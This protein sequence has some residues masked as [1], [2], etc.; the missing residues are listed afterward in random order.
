[1]EE[2]VHQMLREHVN[3]EDSIMKAL[4]EASSF[5]HDIIGEGLLNAGIPGVPSRQDSLP[6]ESWMRDSD[7]LKLYEEPLLKKGEYDEYGITV[8][9][10]VWYL[11]SLKEKEKMSDKGFDEFVKVGDSFWRSGMAIEYGEDDAQP[12]LKDTRNDLGCFAPVSARRNDARSLWEGTSGITGHGMYSNG[13]LEPVSQ[14]WM[15]DEELVYANDERAMLSHEDHLHLVDAVVNGMYTMEDMLSF[16]LYYG[17]IVLGEE[18]LNLNEHLNEAWNL[19]RR[20]CLFYMRGATV[21]TDDAAFS[22]ARTQATSDMWRFACILEKQCPL[23]VLTL[24][25]RLCVVHLPRQELVLGSV[26]A[27]MEFWV[28]RGVQA[29]KGCVQNATNFPDIVMGNRLTMRQSLD[30]YQFSHHDMRQLADLLSI[31][32]GKVIRKRPAGD[33]DIFRD[34][35]V[36]F[37]GAATRSSCTDIQL[38]SDNPALQKMVTDWI[39]ALHGVKHTY[40]TIL[41]FYLV[42]GKE[43]NNVIRRLAKMKMYSTK[44]A[45]NMECVGIDVLDEAESAQELILP[46]SCIQNKVIFHKPEAGGD[47]HAIYLFRGLRHLRSKPT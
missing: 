27:I 22:S 24:N 6:E 28:E 23:N 30:D 13:Y 7:I 20:A 12:F 19:L 8:G 39:F 35:G 37:L 36:Y 15:G 14:T 26:S 46:I 21:Y 17:M 38:V 5:D 34:D 47:I 18:L 41:S 31:V 16:V 42:L 44:S 2:Q 10:V 3:M 45:P 25:L 29:M 1:M 4:Q 32:S 11:L 33:E 9:E 43:E 40:A